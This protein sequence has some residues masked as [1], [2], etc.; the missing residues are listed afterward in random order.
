MTNQKVY[1]ELIYQNRPLKKCVQAPLPCLSPAPRHFSHFFL[2][3]NFPPPPWSLEQ[4]N[5]RQESAYE[6][7][8][9][10]VKDIFFYRIPLTKTMKNHTSQGKMIQQ[11][12][13]LKSKLP[14]YHSKKSSIPQ[15]CKPPCPPQYSNYFV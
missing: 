14:K 11:Y 2:L 3:N 13:T 12:H 9:N 7:Y 1:Q 8:R 6:W 10:T 15:Y 5:V 4:A